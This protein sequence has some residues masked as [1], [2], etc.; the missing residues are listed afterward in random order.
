MNKELILEIKNGGL[1]DHL[2][3]SHIP[4]I[5][6]QAGF[7]KV[8]ISNRSNLRNPIYKK[9]IWEMNPHIDGFVDTEGLHPE[10]SEVREGANI[11]DEIML[12][13]GLDD[14]LRFHEPEIY[15]TP[16]ILPELQ[17]MSL[18]D[19]NYISNAGFCTAR[20][21]KNYFKKNGIHINNQMYV[22]EKRSL[23]ITDFDSFIKTPNFWDFLDVLYSVD[24]IYCTVTGTATLA[25]ALKK[26]ANIFFT[27]DQKPMFRHSRL[28]TYI[29][30]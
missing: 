18:Y 14:N 3:Y 8:F 25:A 27:G 23:P 22:R 7:R 17:G 11:L 24:N 28:H 19:P 12:R 26:P 5:A 29:L 13:L 2:F 1:G 10:F 9:L 30:L 4:R 21:I 6:K 20:K 15:Y 16:K